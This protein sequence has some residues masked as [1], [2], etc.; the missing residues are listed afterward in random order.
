[1]AKRRKKH[2]NIW[3]TE[4]RNLCPQLRPWHVLF[5]TAFPFS[6][7]LFLLTADN[8]YQSSASGNNLFQTGISQLQ[9][10]NTE[11]YNPENLLKNCL[12]YLFIYLFAYLLVNYSWAHM[13]YGPK[14]QM[15]KS[16]IFI[17]QWLGKIYVIAD[18]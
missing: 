7:H 6:T 18:W 4:K 8:L 14:L 2:V 1:M 17:F 12:G 5:N 11:F 13:C 16:H 3:I 15:N 10:L 9:G